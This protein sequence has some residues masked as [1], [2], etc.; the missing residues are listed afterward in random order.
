MYKLRRLLDCSRAER[1]TCVGEA[2][3]R[4]EPVAFHARNLLSCLRLG[5][6]EMTRLT[7]K[8]LNFPQHSLN[9]NVA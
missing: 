9:F 7:F 6:F 1:T 2:R 3:S 4:R 8:R 5:C